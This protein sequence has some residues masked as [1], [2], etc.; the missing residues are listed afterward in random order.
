MMLPALYPAYKSA[1]WLRAGNSWDL[2]KSAPYS[3]G[4]RGQF[5]QNEDHTHSDRLG[6]LVGL[7]SSQPAACI[8]SEVTR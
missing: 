6:W 2:D 8:F 3:L 4:L 1:V 7:P 5:A